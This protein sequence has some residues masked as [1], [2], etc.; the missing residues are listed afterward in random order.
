MTVYFD[1]AATTQVCPEAIKASVSAMGEF[2]GNPSSGYVLG[3]QASEKLSEA[4]ERVAG[5]LGAE[6]EEVHFTS[7]GTEG[8]NWA[9]RSSM[10]LMRHKGRHIITTAYEHDAV[11][12]TVKALEAAGAEVTWLFPESDGRVS[13]GAVK[14]ALRDDTVFISVMLVNNETGAI[15]PIREI[16][17]AIREQGSAAILHTDAVQGF[18]KV[19]FTP[20]KLGADLVTI[21]SHKI[22]GPKGAGALYIRKGLRLPP[23]IT[24]GGQESGLR[25]GTEAMP[26][27][28]G[29]GAAAA[30]GRALMKE[31][32]ET[33][34]SVREYTEALL[35][36]ALPDCRILCEGGAPHILSISLPGWRSEVLMN[37]LD[38]AGICVSKSSACKKG[39]RSHVLE[40]IK[41]PADVIDGAIRVSFSRYN[42]LQEA[43]Y[44]IKTLTEATERLKAAKR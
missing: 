17:N 39:A 34:G 5:A 26:A 10:F 11:R 8:D 43:E 33:M 36:A 35:Q 25:P 32:I 15:N 22:H 13:A 27:L 3:R 41:L 19:P 6:M 16:A 21:S 31:S 7:G 24:G 29:F 42:T 38:A 44:F 30:A 23:M 2:Y 40:T 4:R 37:Y 18:L 9:V 1:N 12:Q 20:K 14:D 28:L